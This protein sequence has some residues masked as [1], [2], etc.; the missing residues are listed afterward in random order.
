MLKNIAIKTIG[1][2]V[3]KQNANNKLL[4]IAYH[5][6][7]DIPDPIQKQ[8]VDKIQ[9]DWQME[10]LNKYFNVL[11]LTEAV[12]RLSS[13]GLPNRAIAV[14]FDDG[15]ADNHDIAL[16]ILKKWNIPATFFISTG[17]INGGIMW[18]DRII[19]SIR[20]VNDKTLDL[21]NINYGIY[22]I[23]SI[24]SRRNTISDLLNRL[25]YL[26]FEKRH[27]LVDS[28]VD[29]LGVKMP[30]NLMMTSE[31]INNLSHNDM[32]IGAHTVNHPILNSISTKKAQWEITQSKNQLKEIISKD[33]IAFAYPNGRPGKDYNKTHVEFVKSAG[34]KLSVSTA[35]GVA[36]VGVD[37]FQLP[38][39]GSWDSNP[40]RFS[41]RLLKTY[42][43]GMPEII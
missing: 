14:T 15:Y 24:E 10:T 37:Q 8:I 6:V 1:N 5:R 13:G 42:L 21:T 17:F 12:E 31:Q 4:I 28:I 9:F 41:M 35:W 27:D 2:L 25:K 7:L 40:T 38:R 19:E 23:D 11:P 18:N 20:K 22:N 30:N 34:F 29:M 39:I 16:P 3:S 43:D 33:V 26:S 36:K 32:G